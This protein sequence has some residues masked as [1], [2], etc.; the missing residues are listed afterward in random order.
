MHGCW[1][2]GHPI[3]ADF[4]QLAAAQHPEALGDLAGWAVALPNAEAA[5]DTLDLAVVATMLARG[6]LSLTEPWLLVWKD[7]QADGEE[8]GSADGTESGVED[9]GGED[10]RHFNIPAGTPR[11]TGGSWAEW[12]VDTKELR[13]QLLALVLF[14]LLALVRTEVP[15]ALARS[16]GWHSG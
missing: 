5:V 2:A 16:V 11:I 7:G 9:A 1:A 6:E 8:E 14:Q 10:S 12:G 13:I 3:T 15:R 4:K